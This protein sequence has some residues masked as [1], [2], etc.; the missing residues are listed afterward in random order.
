MQIRIRFFRI[1][2]ETYPGRIRIR[3]VSDTDTPPP[4][5]IR[6]AEAA[7]GAAA[8]AAPSG[9]AP[10][11]DEG[12]ATSVSSLSRDCRRM[13]SPGERL[14]RRQKPSGRR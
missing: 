14:E 5:S 4:R 12:L 10:G 13:A 9:W 8:A 1:R 11:V 7:A 6:V 3:Y 2:L